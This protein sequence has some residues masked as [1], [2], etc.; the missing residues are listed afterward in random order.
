MFICFC[1]LWR[2]RRA[3]GTKPLIGVADSKVFRRGYFDQPAELWGADG[4]LLATSVQTVY[5]K[6]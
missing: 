2:A 6:E 1:G 5:F 4:T 3:Q